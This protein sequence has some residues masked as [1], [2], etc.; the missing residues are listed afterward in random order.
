VQSLLSSQL[1]GVGIWHV[2]LPS[3]KGAAKYLPFVQFAEPQTVLLLYFWHAPAPLQYPV[4]PQLDVESFEH[5]PSGSLLLKTKAQVPSVLP[6]LDATH[7]LQSPVHAELQHMLSA[8]NPL[9]HCNAL[10]Q[11]LPFESLTI[12]HTPSEHTLPVSQT[13]PHVPQLFSSV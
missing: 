5:S 11:A 9:K 13:F 7:D 8:Q 10:E 4:W 12:V 2:L 1:T 3:H 6:V